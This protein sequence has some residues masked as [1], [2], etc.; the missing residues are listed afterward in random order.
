[1]IFILYLNLKCKEYKIWYAQSKNRYK[2]NL[3]HPETILQ[4]SICKGQCKFSKTY[5]Q[6]NLSP[7]AGR[8]SQTKRAGNAMY[9]NFSSI[10]NY[11]LL[12]TKSTNGKVCSC[13]SQL[14]SYII[15]VVLKITSRDAIKFF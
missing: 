10:G 5:V 11:I 15:S 7:M 12:S 8:S 9:L 14:Q 13:D 2:C 4:L 1:M 6:Q 3:F